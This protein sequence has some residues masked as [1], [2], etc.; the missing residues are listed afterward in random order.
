MTSQ[1]TTTALTAT[2]GLLVVGALAACGSPGGASGSSATSNPSSTTSSP[3]STSSTAGPS[4]TTVTVTVTAGSPTR[5]PHIDPSP[6]TPPA[7]KDAPAIPR[8]AQD[9]GTAFVKAWV[10]D[11]RTRADQ[12]GTPASVK[13]AFA[14]RVDT[15]PRFVRCEGAAG[16]S[17]CTWQ[18]DEYTMQVRLRNDLASLGQPHAVA[19]VVFQH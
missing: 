15:M 14:S 18:G 19:E 10:D 9:Y 13:A 5:T 12:L 17:Y 7:A 8:S 4:P 6:T 3:S 2:A 1:R 16:S 11:D